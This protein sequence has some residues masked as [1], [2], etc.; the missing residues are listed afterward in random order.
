MADIDEAIKYGKKAIGA[1]PTNV[2]NLKQL[3]NLLNDRYVST[4]MLVDL[5]ASILA[6]KRAIDVITNDDVE[7]ADCLNTL[8]YRLQDRFMV[9][10]NN[11]DLEEAIQISR[12]A[13]ESTSSGNAKYLSNLAAS[14]KTRFSVTG[15]L[16]DMEDGI[17]LAK[18]AVSVT[19]S[20]DPELPKF[21]ERPR[22]S[23]QREQ[24]CNCHN[25]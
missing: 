2:E 18:Q 22:R 23:N 14:L 6:T 12:K 11:A 20:D 9:T 21:P 13:I 15:D 19:A 3:G 24:T 16:K 7:L 8:S 17:V 1:N 5:E 4:G 10:E 25:V